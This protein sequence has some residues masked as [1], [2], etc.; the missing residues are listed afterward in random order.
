MRRPVR[1]LGFTLIE[2]VL[3]LL[4]IAVCAS[5]AAPTLSGFARARALP[6]TATDL[7]TTARWCRVQSLSD[8]VEYRLNLDKQGGKW[9]VTKDDGT[10]SNFTSVSPE[11]GQ[12]RPLPEGVAIANIEF[13]TLPAQGDVPYVSF[14]PGGKTD[15]ARITLSYQSQS[16]VVA[17]DTPLG[18]FHVVETVTQ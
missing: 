15:V 12:E 9:W 1:Q 3:V 16:V 17:C 5:I 2:L 8:G 13:Q 10:G 6:N 7:V 14:R 11:L 18:S 4:I